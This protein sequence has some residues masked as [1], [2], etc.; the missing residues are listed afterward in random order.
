MLD[1]LYANSK[2]SVSS[3]YTLKEVPV[4]EGYIPPRSTI[5]M[6]EIAKAT[7]YY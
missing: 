7:K 3:G 1:Y 2:S 5:A 4:Q 6:H